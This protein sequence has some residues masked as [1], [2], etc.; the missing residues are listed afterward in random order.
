MYA[1]HRLHGGGSDIVIIT[2]T[3][4]KIQLFNGNKEAFVINSLKLNDEQWIEFLEKRPS[5]TE[6]MTIV[7]I[8]QDEVA[9]AEAGDIVHIEPKFKP[10]DSVKSGEILL[11]VEAVKTVMDVSSPFDGILLAYKD[12]LGE[13][14]SDKNVKFKYKI[15]LLLD[16]ASDFDKMYHKGEN[17]KNNQIILPSKSQNNITLDGTILYIGEVDKSKANTFIVKVQVQDNKSEHNIRYFKDHDRLQKG[18]NVAI[19]AYFKDNEIHASSIDIQ[20]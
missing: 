15:Y 17:D 11:E 1:T 19:L 7:E 16:N 12:N 18:N 13:T 5:D 4:D 9:C 20:S 14:V 6:E 8:S 3:H 2:P 10:H